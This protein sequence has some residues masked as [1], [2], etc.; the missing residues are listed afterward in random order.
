MD[1][2]P[3]EL[4]EI[5]FETLPVKDL[6]STL[7]VCK[8]WRRLALADRLWKQHSDIRFGGPKVDKWM[9][10]FTCFSKAMREWIAVKEKSEASLTILWAARR[11]H[12]AVLLYE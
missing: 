2:L 4:V 3:K 5:I 11:G 10:W 9:S 12:N 8:P 6:A 7:L 1:T